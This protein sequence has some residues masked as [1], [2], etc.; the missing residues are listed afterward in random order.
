MDVSTRVIMLP[1]IRISLRRASS[2]SST[3]WISAVPFLRRIAAGIVHLRSLPRCTKED[4]RGCDRVGK[5]DRM[6]THRQR[7]AAPIWLGIAYASNA[8]RASDHVAFGG[9]MK[10]IRHTRPSASKQH[11]CTGA[12][13]TSRSCPYERRPDLRMYQVLIMHSISQ[14]RNE[15]RSTGREKRTIDSSGGNTANSAARGPD[16]TTITDFC[17]LKGAMAAGRSTL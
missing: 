5:R 4:V 3:V 9:I 16:S 1:S 2:R 17:L 11:R 8:N 15:G 7:R 10:A 12:P 13:T 6:N 14:L